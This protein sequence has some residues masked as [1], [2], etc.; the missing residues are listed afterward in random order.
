MNE[1]IGRRIVAIQSHRPGNADYRVLAA[2]I[3][4]KRERA[5]AVINEDRLARG[6]VSFEIVRDSPPI[7]VFFERVVG[8]D[9]GGRT[10]QKLDEHQ[11]HR[12][13]PSHP[14]G[15]RSN[16]REKQQFARNE[17]SRDVSRKVKRS[18]IASDHDTEEAGAHRDEEQ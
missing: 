1:R 15:S 4:Q 5:V 18:R 11:Q 8:C 2:K 17:E 12:G 14:D 9:V 7:T 16:E 3:V 10:E 6:G 13:P